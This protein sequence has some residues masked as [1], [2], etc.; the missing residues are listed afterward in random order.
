MGVESVMV[1]LGAQ[2]L[3]EGETAFEKPQRVAM[4]RWARTQESLRWRGDGVGEAGEGGWCSHRRGEC[5]PRRAGLGL[6]CLQG[7]RTDSSCGELEFRGEIRDTDISE[8][9]IHAHLDMEV[10]GLDEIPKGENNCL[11]SVGYCHHSRSSVLRPPSFVTCLSLT[12]AI[13]EGDIG[14][15]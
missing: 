7:I 2:G 10:T 3:L 12:L 4:E 5:Q 15:R 6:E 14:T 13:L 8:P 11:G 1:G 9:L